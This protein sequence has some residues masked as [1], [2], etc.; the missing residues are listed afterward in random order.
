MNDKPNKPGLGYYF[1]ACL[2]VIALALVA[3]G[4][5]TNIAA[6]AHTMRQASENA[7]T[8]VAEVNALHL[9]LLAL[10]LNRSLA[11][12]DDRKT[13]DLAL[14]GLLLNSGAGIAQKLRRA[15]AGDL[16]ICDVA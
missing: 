9:A 15:G 2:V 16:F 12:A 4:P 3:T 14:G 13:R 5:L 8:T 10:I 1:F 6:A 11:W 7:V